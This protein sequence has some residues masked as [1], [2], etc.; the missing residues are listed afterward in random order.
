MNQQEFPTEI[1]EEMRRKLDEYLDRKTAE[2]LPDAVEADRF[3]AKV[4]AVDIKV[5]AILDGTLELTDVDREE[6]AAEERKKILAELKR[7]DAEQVVFNGKIGKGHQGGYAVM[8]K[9]CMYEYEVELP[10]CTHCQKS[11]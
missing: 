4:N 10:Q 11:D 3:L 8:C 7:R 2:I 6:M 1:P 9:R 5:R